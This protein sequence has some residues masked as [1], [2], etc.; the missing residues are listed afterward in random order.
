[1]TL[2]DCAIT[3]PAGL[4]VFAAFVEPSMVWVWMGICWLRQ[5]HRFH[6]GL[7]AHLVGACHPGPVPDG[8]GPGSGRFGS[9][10]VS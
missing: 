5:R 2:A 9:W 10:N 3:L 7:F 8:S 4:P 1:M 6:A